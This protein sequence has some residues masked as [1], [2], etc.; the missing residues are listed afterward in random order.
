[1]Q[2]KKKTQTKKNPKQTNK[3][4]PILLKNLF[5]FSL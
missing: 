4:T 3:Q 2:K 5:W 1:M